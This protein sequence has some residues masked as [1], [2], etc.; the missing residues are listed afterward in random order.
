MLE[1]ETL[2]KEIEVTREDLSWLKDQFRRAA[3]W[4]ADENIHPSIVEWMRSEGMNVRTAEELG[5]KGKDDNAVFALA[6]K[7]DR[8]IL[9]SDEDFWDDL[10]FPIDMC[11]G[12]VIISQDVSDREIAT[13]MLNLREVI[14]PFREISERSKI[15][16]EG[17]G[18]VWVKSRS[19]DTGKITTT[20]YWVTRHKV[21]EWVE[22]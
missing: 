18:R 12:I 13:E 3:K 14:F 21:Y 2:W 1:G 5:L 15:K 17:S 10:K 20:V 19:H 16:L 9:T 4:L 11:P 22:E 8:M 7:H 6:R